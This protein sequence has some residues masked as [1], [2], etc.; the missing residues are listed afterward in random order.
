MTRRSP[1][2]FGI[3]LLITAGAITFWLLRDRFADTARPGAQDVPTATAT[4]ASVSTEPV[5]TVDAGAAD[6]T[7]TTSNR[8]DSSVRVVKI[9]VGFRAAWCVGATVTIIPFDDELI[10]LALRPEPLPRSLIDT[11]IRAET[12][13]DG[14]AD[15]SL[16][17]QVCLVIAE[18]DG[19]APSGLLIDA[20]ATEIGI[21]IHEAAPVAGIVRDGNGNP[22][23]GATV[24]GGHAGRVMSHHPVWSLNGDRLAGMFFTRE[25]TTDAEGRFSLPAIT[26]GCA[27]VL[28]TSPEHASCYDPTV[29][30]PKTDIEI[31]LGRPASVF[32]RVVEETTG[33]P[34]AGA[35]VEVHAPIAPYGSPLR[36]QPAMTGE[37]GNFAISDAPAQ[38]RWSLS[39]MRSGYATALVTQEPLREGEH[40]R[41]DASIRTAS[42]LEGSVTSSVSGE[43]IAEARVAVHTQPDGRYVGIVPTGPDGIFRADFV[44][45][46]RTY[47]LLAFDDD[48]D[49]A[50]LGGV[51]VDGERPAIQ[52]DP[53]GRIGGSVLQPADVPV[54]GRVQLS[55]TNDRGMQPLTRHTPIDDQGD[56]EFTGV[57]RGRYT[58]TPFVDGY[59]PDP[60]EEITVHP[61]ATDDEEFDIDL[62][63]GVPLTGRVVDAVDGAPIS[64]ASVSLAALSGTLSW[65]PLPR[66]TTTDSSGYYR[67]DDV[68]AG[69]TVAVVVRGET[70][71]DTLRSV[72]IPRTAPQARLDVALPGP[73]TI[74]VRATRPSGEPIPDFDLLV[75]SH[76]RIDPRVP[77]VRGVAT[78][79]RLE[80]GLVRIGI[81]T[82]HL[83]GQPAAFWYREVEVEAGDVRD[84]TFELSEGGTI[85]GQ[86]VGAMA[87]T[88]VRRLPLV[89]W[90][91]LDAPQVN[92]GHDVIEYDNTFVLHGV[93]A[94][95]I[96]VWLAMADQG[97]GLTDSMEV[98]V[99]EDGE[100]EVVFEFGSAVV[101]GR[102]EDPRGSPIADAMV[103]LYE[104]AQLGARPDTPL[105]TS[106]RS[107]RTD[108]AGYF[109]LVGVT[110][111]PYLVRAA[112]RASA[113]VHSELMLHD[114]VP[115]AWIDIV[116]EEE[117]TLRAHAV[118]PEG[119]PIAAT[120]TCRELR[121]DVSPVI[122]PLRSD[123]GPHL[124]QGM[125]TGSYELTA[126]ASP[127]FPVTATIDIVA[128]ESR[129][130][131]LPLRARGDLRVSVLD[132]TGKPVVAAPL[133]V[134][135][136]STGADAAV[137]S[138]SGE[139]V[140]EP[141]AEDSGPLRTDE[142][143]L[144]LLRGIPLG[145]YEVDAFGLPRTVAVEAGDEASITLQAL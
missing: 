48:Y 92:S 111:G 120:I 6:P 101:Q 3:A 17:H 73:A 123:S 125:A 37:D 18:T 39:V 31:T 66:A 24:R 54:P 28:V 131:V 98:T 13:E 60:S 144:L 8:E 139:I 2:V 138:R 132:A 70:Y 80:P 72:F 94:G 117:A 127:Y 130:I 136:Q 1:R 115:D 12:G 124:F 43:P 121:R 27:Y 75:A 119:H 140:A 23:A 137:W 41:V 20:E 29:W 32:G 35:F 52:L 96:E 126:I 44:E 5:D 135:D 68:P 46:E 106:G 88:L 113:T 71:A 89:K 114:D 63:A 108:E 67:I 104:L 95:R 134:V 129:E 97:P 53:L 91:T 25:T 56:Y 142:H 100:H 38:I 143:G 128:G 57:K 61:P 50:F 11:A 49:K 82:P 47:A 55:M 14:H 58:L 86:V 45:P 141:S 42:L 102:V 109:D 74:H 15:V 19:G 16:P 26:P 118:A 122:A 51:H 81:H 40:R 85:R 30:A 83:A 10:Q 21:G 36:A 22:V 59:A 33:E 103:E 77:A 78:Y 84:V 7:S 112:S 116:L 145:E 90:R 69:E 107:T 79:E 87:S 62:R 99:T 34:V 65:G 105:R 133:S 9:G 93:P 64:N 76:G 4:D 110:P